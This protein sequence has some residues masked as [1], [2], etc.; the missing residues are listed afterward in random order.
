LTPFLLTIGKF[1]SKPILDSELKYQVMLLDG[2]RYIGVA[3]L[4]VARNLFSF[5][6]PGMASVFFRMCSS[7]L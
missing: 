7:M 6:T 3:Q 4:V 1:I 2:G 5:L